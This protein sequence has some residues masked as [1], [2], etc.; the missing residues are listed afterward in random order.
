MANNPF[1]AFL[2][3]YGIR[4]LTT[5]NDGYLPGIVLE[6]NRK[7]FTSFG[8]LKSVLD[9]PNRSWET[10]LRESNLIN[11]TINRSL[12]LK[13]TAS[14]KEFG[15]DISGGLQKISS[16][17]FAIEQVTAR[18]FVHI[19]NFTLMPKILALKKKDKASWKMLKGKWYVYHLFYASH[20]VFTFHGEAAIDVKA[21]IKNKITIQP[22]ASIRWS[23]NKQF[24]VTKNNRVPFGFAGWKI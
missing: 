1:K 20:L 3:S 4:L 23:S 12:S 24:V 6:K 9:L 22:E 15:V 14:L 17:D 21:L 19:D 8:H 13:T 10:Q 5:P 2:T 11:E 7:A 16:V 18:D